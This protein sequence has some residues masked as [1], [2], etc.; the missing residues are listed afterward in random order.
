MC[1]RLISSIC[2][3]LVIA[4]FGGIAA[5][6]R[7]AAAAGERFVGSDGYPL[8]L[9]PAGTYLEGC[10][11]GQ[12]GGCYNGI[13]PA[14]EVT[15]SRSV[16]VGEVEVTQG[17]YWRLTGRNPSR[18][19]SCGMDC[20]VERV[21]WYDAVK[22]ANRLSEAE[23]LERCYLIAGDSVS[24]PDGPACLGYRLPTSAEWEVAARGGEDTVYAGGD[25]L[26][27]VGWYRDNSGPGPIRASGRP[28]RGS[29]TQ[30]V[31]Q[32]AANGYGLH[33]MSGNVFEWVWDWSI[34]GATDRPVTDPLGPD[35]GY[36]RVYRGGSWSYG[37][38]ISRMVS[39]FAERP[40]YRSS[41]LGVRLVRT[42]P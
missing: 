20:P 8:R 22:L 29:S 32:K 31:R 18:F 3:L 42:A 38:V 24:W 1:G 6:P 27:A 28:R 41:A 21:S 25:W 19:K 30:P 36:R 37:A 23:G 2:V 40:T 7:D 9:V 39:R 26:D 4:I 12:V 35:S 33:D 34:A 5:A 11:P 15:L 14:R 17:L 13:K 10:T 16:L